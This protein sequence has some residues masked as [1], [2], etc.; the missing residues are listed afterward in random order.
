[1][2]EVTADA[3]EIAREVEL[4]VGPEDVTEL[5]QSND[6]TSADEELL[7]TDEQRQWFPEME[8]TP[9]E[10]A[11]KMVETTTKD[12]EY[13]INLVHKAVAGSERI[14]CKFESSTVDKMLSKSIACYREI[15]R[16]G[17]SRSM[18][19]TPLLSYFK[20][21]SWPLLP[22]A[23]STPISQRPSTQEARPSTSIKVLT[24]R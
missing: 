5:L 19:Q 4:E 18:W 21:L 6:K 17:R 14:D 2:E 10:D 15:I 20:E 8:S 7:R 22:S 3:V 13:F 11:A 1:M 12:L 9:G 24:H 16:E 23:T